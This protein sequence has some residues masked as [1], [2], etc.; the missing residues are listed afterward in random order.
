MKKQLSAM[1]LFYTI[2]TSHRPSYRF[3]AADGG[4]LRAAHD[5]CE[6]TKE[7]SFKQQKHHEDCRCGRRKPRT[8]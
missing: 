2:T 3:V 4:Q 8:V 5:G 1:S 7:Q 6:E